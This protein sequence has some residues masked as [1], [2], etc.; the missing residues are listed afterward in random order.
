MVWLSL[1][2]GI[3]FTVISTVNE[4]PT[5]P[6]AVGVIVY[7]TIPGPLFGGGGSL[8]IASE[9]LINPCSIRFPQAAAQLEKPVIVYGAGGERII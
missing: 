8:G 6:F 3:G 7:L 1:N 9:V 4:A 2:S 5:H